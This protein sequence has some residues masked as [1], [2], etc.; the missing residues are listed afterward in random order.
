[1]E[2]NGL[3]E[4]QRD[5]LRASKNTKKEMPKIMRKIGSKARV[6]VAKKAR[7]L[8][9]KKTGNY[10]KGWKRGKVF[11]GPDGAVTVRVYNGSP[12]AH[13]IED[14]HKM[15][16]AEGEFL[17]TYVHGKEVRD[18]GMREFEDSKIAEQMMSDWLDT[19]LEDNK[20]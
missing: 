8:V 3:N 11:I 4:L 14:G 20:L 1:M 10:Q 7:T 2:I 17:G 9:K 6:V 18:K 15:V 19:L 5:L 13:L 12:H 16:S